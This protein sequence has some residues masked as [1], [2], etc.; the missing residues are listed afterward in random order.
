MRMSQKLLEFQPVFMEISVQNMKVNILPLHTSHIMEGL[1]W[2]PESQR[3]DTEKT[4][5]DNMRLLSIMQDLKNM[6]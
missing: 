1:H 6:T 2:L 5:Y 3:R 4:S